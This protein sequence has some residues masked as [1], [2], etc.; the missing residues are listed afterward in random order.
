MHCQLREDFAITEPKV[1]SVCQDIGRFDAGGIRF[2]AGEEED[3]HEVWVAFSDQFSGDTPEIC[4]ELLDCRRIG[5][6]VQ[7]L[8]SIAISAAAQSLSFMS[9]ALETVLSTPSV[10][11]WRTSSL[12]AL[13]AS[14]VSKG[15]SLASGAASVASAT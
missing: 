9:R 3:A 8:R 11:T 4:E 10:L 5:A 6:L 15:L 2:S 14:T 1:P 13:C 7:K 12:M